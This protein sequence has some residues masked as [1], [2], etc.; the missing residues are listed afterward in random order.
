MTT[1]TCTKCGETKTVDQFGKNRSH[2]DGLQSRC[3]T[4]HNACQRAY[5]DE[6]REERATYASA[7]Y[8][9]NRDKIT[10]RV[11]AYSKANQDKII[12][13]REANRDRINAR[14]RAHYN[15]VGKPSEKRCREIAARYATRAGEP[16][17]QEEDR[18]L[19]DGPGTIMNKA[20]QLSRTYSA[21][22][23]RRTTLLRQDNAA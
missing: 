4:C 10:A 19:I 20:L 1:K 13:Y 12:A 3:K 17:T 18:Y 11:S 9:A 2:P 15:L 5:Y 22:R 6:N 16:W 21:T 7:Y 23:T 8:E 14:N